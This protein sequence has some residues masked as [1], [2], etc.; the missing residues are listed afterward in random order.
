[1]LLSGL[2]TTLVLALLSVAAGTLLGALI[3]RLRMSRNTL[4]EAFAR[5][6]VRVIQGIPILVLLMLLYYVILNS[7]GLSAPEICVIGFSLDFAAYASEIFRSGIR[8]VPPGQARAAKA[9]G[10]GRV[11]GFVKVV[12]PQALRH[13]LPVYSGQVISLVKITSVAG[14]ISVLELTKVSDIIRSRTFDAFF[15]LITSA[16]VYFLLA[17]LLTGLMRLASGRLFRRGGNRALRELQGL[18]AGGSRTETAAE[19]APRGTEL[20]TVEHLSKRF[21]QVTPIRDVSCT[22]RSG[23][24]ISVIGPSG[25]GKSTFLNLINRLE[26]PDGGRILYAGEDT[27]AK[28]CDL[29]RLRQRVGMVFQSFNLFSHLTVVENVMLAQTELKKR[30]RQEA[31][32]RAMAL[33]EAVGLSG[34]ALS[35]PSELSGGQQQRAAIARTLAMDPEIVLFDEPTS[36]L[37]PTMVGEVLAVIRKLAQK[38]VTML[39]VTHE[40]QFARDVS[41][42]V[43]YMD[44]G[45]IYEEGSPE[46]VFE[47]PEKEKTRQFI[48]RLKVF[49]WRIEGDAPDFPA[50]IGAV[51]EFA[52][53]HMLSRR[54]YN[55][56]MT[57][58]EEL[59]ID[60]VFSRQSDHSPIDLDAEYDRDREEIRFTVA[61]TGGDPLLDADALP[62]RLLRN[63]CSSLAFT[64]REDRSCVEG[65]IRPRPAE[66]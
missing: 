40:M 19:G 52:Q 30:S 2:G 36:A 44:E 10:F 60:R 34:K 21:G 41:T 51:E 13:I 59:C 27:C 3:C 50:L 63:A 55:G 9:L 32:G 66:D 1:M 38:G 43:F 58:A 23:D 35:Y 5:L 46:K 6:Y 29:T 26:E 64:R 54:L 45:V 11:R 39:V 31:Y 28:G 48:R 18:S 57:V 22:V 24:V 53:K 56:L 62:V 7:R 12:L 4:A 17:H 47:Q 14:Y 49:H 65:W 61:F 20:L 8:A 16:L 25:T 15:P 42:R 33:L 37:D